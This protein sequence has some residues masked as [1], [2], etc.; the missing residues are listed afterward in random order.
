MNRVETE[1]VSYANLAQPVTLT[2]AYDALSR[3]VS[4]TACQSALNF[5]PLSASNVDPLCA[6]Q[7]RR[8]VVSI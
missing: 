3:R 1:T 2:Y 4:V 7:A 6:E 8:C 5:N